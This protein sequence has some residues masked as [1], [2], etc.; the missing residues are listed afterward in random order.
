MLYVSHF[1]AGLLFAAAMLT[2][3]Y[4]G[5]EMEACADKLLLLSLPK[6]V[7]ELYLVVL[8]L[9]LGCFYSVSMPYGQPND[10]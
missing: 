10:C 8:T 7:Q 3:L 6:K 4:K 2:L 9:S 5:K 1:P